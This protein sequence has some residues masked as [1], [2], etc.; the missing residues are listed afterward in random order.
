MKTCQQAGGSGEN[1][2]NNMR[3]QKIKNPV[4]PIKIVDIIEFI[5]F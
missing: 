2:K 4:N 1:L 5:I 3:S